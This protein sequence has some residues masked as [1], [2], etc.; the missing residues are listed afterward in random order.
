MATGANSAPTPTS[1]D[2]DPGQ[3]LRRTSPKHGQAIM[4]HPGET[5]QT[6]CHDERRRNDRTRAPHVVG[7]DGDPL[8]LPL[9]M[10]TATGDNP[11][12]SLTT[13]S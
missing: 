13:S 10:F 5:G 7:A 4:A 12:A 11:A 9:A 8:S 1:N 3:R 6:G 2:R